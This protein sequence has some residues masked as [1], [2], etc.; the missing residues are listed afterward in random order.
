MITDARPPVP[1]TPGSGLEYSPVPADGWR[2][3]QGGSTCRWHAPAMGIAVC[4]K[5]A[6]AEKHHPGDPIA[7]WWAYCAEHLPGGKE[8]FEIV[9]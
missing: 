3:A 9:Y 2:A 4:G 5:P 8:P 6:V 7:N 1:E